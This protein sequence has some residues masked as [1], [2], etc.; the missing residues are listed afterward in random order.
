MDDEVY[1]RARVKAAEQDTSVS[2]L[3]RQFLVDLAAGADEFERLERLEQ[4]VR[5]QITD[6][7]ASDRLSRDELYDRRR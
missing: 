1:R 2:A 7:S 4:A 3:V 5:E 6:F